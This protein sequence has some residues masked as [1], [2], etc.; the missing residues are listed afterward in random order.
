LSTHAGRS[1]HSPSCRTPPWLESRST[2]RWYPK[3]TRRRSNVRPQKTF[4]SLEFSAQELRLQNQV[5]DES[6]ILGVGFVLDRLPP[7]ALL[8]LHVG[9]VLG[10]AGKADVVRDHDSS[11]VQPAPVDEPLQVGQIHV[12]PVIEEYEIQT[13][14]GESVVFGENLE[15]RPVADGAVDAG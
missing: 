12:L 7:F 13:A 1:G 11:R 14:L 15:C 5:F 10:C 6:L 4:H 3:S 2:T 9:A 8:F